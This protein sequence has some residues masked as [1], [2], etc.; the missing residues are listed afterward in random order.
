MTSLEDPPK[1]SDLTTKSIQ[2][3]QSHSAPT[4]PLPE[5]KKRIKFRRKM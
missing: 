4:S 3:Y 1:T 5:V 2:P